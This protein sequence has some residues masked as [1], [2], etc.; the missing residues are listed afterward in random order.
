MALE[1]IG[2]MQ[3]PCT[4]LF[5]F[6]G[7]GNYGDDLMAW[8]IADHLESIGRRV[9]IYSLSDRAGD[10]LQSP[11]FKRRIFP[12]SPSLEVALQ[13]CDSVIYGGGGVLVS[14]ASRK[15]RKFACYFR[16]EEIFLAAVKQRQLPLAVL[17]VGGDGRQ[18][19]GLLDSFAADMV[20]YATSVTVRNRADVSVLKQL[21]VDAHF[22]PDIVWG[23]KRSGFGVRSQHA[24][25]RI[26]LDLYSNL[27]RR[28]G[29]LRFLC[30][31][32][33][34]ILSNPSIRFVCL[35][36]THVNCGRSSG[37][38]RILFG[39]NVERYQF[40]DFSLDHERLC[41]LDVLVSS[42]LHVPMVALQCGVPVISVFSEGKTRL[43][44]ESVGLQFAHFDKTRIRELQSILASRERLIDW[45]E[46]YHFPPVDVLSVGA[47]GHYRQMDDFLAEVG[48][49]RK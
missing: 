17:S 42:R 15:L 37:L 19:A 35:N 13:S 40:S 47:S 46:R 6:Y 20:R 23:V 21:G 16:R 33:S 10:S 11:N 29:G 22:H 7:V 44:M 38:G 14:N 26:G 43:L 32:Q 30:F 2:S 28:G 41:S 49:C 45:I 18:D 4:A 8:M 25:L 39:S 34:V 27:F 31:L 24:Q 36:S 3:T 12:S 5:G 48:A 1:V 9:I